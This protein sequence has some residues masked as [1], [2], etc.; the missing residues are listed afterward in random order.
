MENGAAE[1]SKGKDST[2]LSLPIHTASTE[3]PDRIGVL[4]NP[5]RFANAVNGRGQDEN[6][7]K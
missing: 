6:R 7:S 2:H 1:R 3:S 4:Q 5:F